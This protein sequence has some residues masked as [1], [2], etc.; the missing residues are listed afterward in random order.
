L[1]WYQD[2]ANLSDEDSYY[3]QHSDHLITNWNSD[4]LPATVQAQLAK[5]R[6]QQ[7]AAN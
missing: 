7:S 2:F 3:I 6:A 4:K 1:P 5:L